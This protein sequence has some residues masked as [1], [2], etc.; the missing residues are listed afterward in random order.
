MK[1]DKI[2]VR[3]Y[4]DI[5]F[6]IDK[7]DS[8]IENMIRLISWQKKNKMVWNVF[9]EILC[10]YIFAIPSISKLS[11]YPLIFIAKIMW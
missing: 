11:L 1:L 9:C 6:E 4:I 3:D 2:G 10:I 7:I 5:D 8:K